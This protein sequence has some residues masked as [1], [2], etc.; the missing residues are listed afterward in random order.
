MNKIS[1]QFYKSLVGELILG[2]YNEKL[3]MADW[4]YRKMRAEI[5]ARIQKGLNAEYIEESTPVIQQTIEQLM[6]YFEGKRKIFD[7]PLELVGT[8]FQK[9]VWQELLKIPFGET[10][11][12]LGLSQKL[13]NEKAIRA[14]AAANGANA[15]SILVPCHRIIGTS[16]KLIGY[17]GGLPAKKKLL[18]LEGIGQDNL[19]MSLFD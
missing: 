6:E 9:S 3:C 16:G 11:T 5:D 14:V 13:G 4:R 10:A 1:I 18:E 8:D 7:I 2:A 12:Y 17:A 15:I 19:Q